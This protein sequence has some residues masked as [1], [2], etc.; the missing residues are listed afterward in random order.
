MKL[1]PSLVVSI[2]LCTAAQA[3]EGT[4]LTDGARKALAVGVWETA[5]AGCASRVACFCATNGVL[6]TIT[7]TTSTT[8]SFAQGVVAAQDR[9][10]QMEL[11]KR[12]GQGK[13]QRKSWE[14]PFCSAN[15]RAALQYPGDMQKSTRATLPTPK[16]TDWVH[17]W[18]LTLTSRR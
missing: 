3:Y 17:R 18:E 8:F 6:H 7:R 9:L 1:I 15:Q 13:A 14:R 2:S 5:C 12:S 11:W 16:D 10:F 4:T